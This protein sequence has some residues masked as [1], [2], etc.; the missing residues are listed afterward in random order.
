VGKKL[1]PEVA[2]DR[3]SLHDLADWHEA[4]TK[5]SKP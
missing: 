2:H 1:D 3:A 5:K 4:R